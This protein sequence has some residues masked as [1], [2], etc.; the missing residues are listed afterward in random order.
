MGYNW[1]TKKMKKMFLF[2]VSL[3]CI[4]MAANAQEASG[5]CKL[6]GTYDYVNVDYYKNGHLAISNQSGLTITQLRVKVTVYEKWKQNGQPV[7][8]TSTLCDK[9]FYDIP[10]YQTTMKTDGVQQYDDRSIMD[11]RKY[12]V[13][14]GNPICK[15]FKE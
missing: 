13:E 3:F 5:G 12:E 15:E 7:E 8:R 10:P 14:V 1:A 4:T 9:N 6:P 11:Y 2:L